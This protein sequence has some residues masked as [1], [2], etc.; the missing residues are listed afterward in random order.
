VDTAVN[1][2]VKKAVQLLQRAV[3]VKDD[4]IFGPV[5]KQAV[6][7]ADYG[8]LYRRLIAE[9]IRF[10]GRIITID[11]TQAKFAAGWANR[12]AEFVESA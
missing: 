5:T 11:P 4:G 6:L 1:A 12:D 10:R 9:R 2:G 8:G 3:G 7:Q